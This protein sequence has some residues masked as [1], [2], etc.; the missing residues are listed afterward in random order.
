[1]SFLITASVLRRDIS[2]GP[3]IITI[4]NPFILRL[5]SS[6]QFWAISIFPFQQPIL[7]R[8]FKFYTIRFLRFRPA[9]KHMFQISWDSPLQTEIYKNQMHY[10]D[11]AT[12]SW[13]WW[14][15]L[16]AQLSSGFAAE[17]PVEQN[18]RLLTWLSLNKTQFTKINANSHFSQDVLGGISESRREPTAPGKG[19]S[20][21]H[22][23]ESWGLCQRLWKQT[24]L[25]PAAL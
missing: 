20:K 17:T 19:S 12:K 21:W 22:S 9:P 2:G 16:K 15:K 5:N 1:M 18:V 14:P 4:Y 13:L 25:Q 8:D 11:T 3:C 6:F 24:R 7:S 10:L 23:L